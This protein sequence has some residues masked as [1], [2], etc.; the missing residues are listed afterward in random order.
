[1]Y[2]VYWRPVYKF[3]LVLMLNQAGL[4]IISLEGVHLMDLI[5]HKVE[6]LIIEPYNPERDKAAIRVMLL[7]GNERFDEM[8]QVSE[9]KCHDG[10][11]S[12]RYNGVTVGF[13]SFDGFKR[14]AETTIFVSKAYRRMGIGT[15]LMKMADKLF[16]QNEAVERSTGVCRDGDRSSLQF[17]YKNGYYI[18][19]SAYI[20]EREGESLPER[21]ISVRQYEND[22]YLICQSISEIAF[23]KMHELVGMLPSFYFPP[24][25]RERKSFLEDRN[26]IFVML[27]DCEIVAV[28]IICGSELCHVSVR[29]ELQARGYGRAFVS[30]L[31][32]EIMRRGEKIV[33]LG[34]VKGNPAK[35]LY[36]SLGFKEKSLNHWVTKYYKPDGRLSRPPNEDIS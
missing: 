20:M 36:E 14:K 17:L 34:V 24:N 11:H 25:E 8:F 22:D 28:G 6:N 15:E 27:I 33:K 32:N 29:P 26:N 19:Y 16:S 31:V 12:A 18:S 21:N 4:E 3:E 30:F 9:K 35:K 1:M 7:C 23:Y 13:L 10:I 5:L 2:S